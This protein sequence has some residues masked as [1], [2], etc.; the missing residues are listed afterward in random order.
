MLFNKNCEQEVIKKNR[1]FYS[2][3]C[4]MTSSREL[5]RFLIEDK[6]EFN[7]E[8]ILHLYLLFLTLY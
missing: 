5:N 6:I 7:F 4:S 3:C 1:E 2:G 8:D